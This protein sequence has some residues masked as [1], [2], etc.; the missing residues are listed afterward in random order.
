MTTLLIEPFG[1]IAG[2]MLLAALLD[3]GD[4]RFTMSHLSALAEE[5]VGDEAE[6]SEESVTRASL[7]AGRLT[8]ATPETANPPHRHLSDL[9]KL[10]EQTDL[11]A[12]ARE[13]ATAALTALA[14]A[15][16]EVHGIDVEQVHFHEVGAVDT[17]IDVAGAALA[18]ELLGV[19]E[20]RATTPLVGEGTIRCAHGEM[21]VPAPAVALLLRGRPVN[22]GGGFERTTPTGAAMLAAWSKPAPNSGFVAT[23]VG[24]GAGTKVAE[25]GPPNLVRVHLGE[26]TTT[27]HEA[28]KLEVTL[29]DMSPE[30]VGHAVTRLRE[31]GA[32]EVWT[33]AVQMKKDRPGIE[34]SALCREDDRPGL[35]AVLWEWT[36]S[37]GCR[38]VKLERTELERSFVQVE[39][40]G[41]SIAVKVRGGG[42]R[43]S[44]FAPEHDDVARAAEALRMPLREVRRLAISTA[45]EA[46]TGP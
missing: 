18:L 15:E 43:P 39:V 19:D 45:I 34:V 7:K 21:P 10:L 12:R 9:L 35:E 17:L 11:P 31:A 25:T 41:Q 29:D 16:A 24:Y 32:L 28:W 20:V 6:L 4:E 27:R 30:E 40:E 23:L 8:V 36:T 33:Q 5:L 2:D 1:G 42:K 44:D 26:T 3:L 46:A 37:F 13:R 38:W 14:E 22:Y